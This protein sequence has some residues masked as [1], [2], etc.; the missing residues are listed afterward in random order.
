MYEVGGWIITE[1]R[2]KIGERM[3]QRFDPDN[4]TEWKFEVINPSSHPDLNSVWVELEPVSE[5]K[6][7]LRM[8][9]CEGEG[10]VTPEEAVEKIVSL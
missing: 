9:G 2:K 1:C 7:F 8:V 4:F 3:I 6:V 10:Y 5:E